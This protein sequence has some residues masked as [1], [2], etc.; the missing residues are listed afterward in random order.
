MENAPKPY[1]P[2]FRDMNLAGAFALTFVFFVLIW[3]VVVS[4]RLLGLRRRLDDLAQAIDA[5][6]AGLKTA[7]QGALSD[8]AFVTP[9]LQ[10]Q[11]LAAIIAA[12]ASS[13]DAGQTARAAQLNELGSTISKL[14]RQRELADAEYSRL[15]ASGLSSWVARVWRLPIG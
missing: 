15:S 13:G 14:K 7:V 8:A 6:E 10:D 2:G 12:L 11:D 9:K 5:G 4:A 1:Y 3:F